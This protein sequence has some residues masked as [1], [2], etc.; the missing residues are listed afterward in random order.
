MKVLDLFLV[1][2]DKM[3]AVFVDSLRGRIY[4]S[5]HGKH[6]ISRAALDGSDQKI[7]V[8]PGYVGCFLYDNSP[9]KRGMYFEHQ[10]P[11]EMC[12]QMRNG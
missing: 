9:N 5:D 3:A 12:E 7:I 6:T 11:N 2:E 10:Q 8:N 1:I 4:W